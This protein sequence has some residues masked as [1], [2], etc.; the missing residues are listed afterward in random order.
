MSD[1]RLVA[2]P[3]VGQLQ[4]QAGVVGRLDGDDIGE[5]VGSQQEAYGLDHVGPLWF[6]SRQRQNRKLLIRSQHHHLRS[7]HHPEDKN[8]E[9][10]VRSSGHHQN[11]GPGAESDLALF[12]L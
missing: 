5:E 11:Q 7:K 8:R 10:M 6:V 1:M 2:S 4:L 12:S 3:V 9:S